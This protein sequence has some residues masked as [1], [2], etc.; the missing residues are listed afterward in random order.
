[1]YIGEVHYIRNGC[2]ISTLMH[3]DTSLPLWA[4]LDI[5]GAVQKVRLLG[6]CSNS[7]CGH[8][9]VHY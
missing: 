6:N 8:F 7:L 5:Y 3:V 1:M 9:Y 4:L 2:Q